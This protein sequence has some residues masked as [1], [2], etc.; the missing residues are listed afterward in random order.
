MWSW[1][2]LWF[3]QAKKEAFALLFATVVLVAAGPL[4]MQFTT[5][6]SP[7]SVASLL[8]VALLSVWAGFRP[9]LLL[10]LGVGA[11]GFVWSGFGW[12]PVVSTFFLISMAYVS[13]T[14]LNALEEQK[15]DF[16]GI[17][18]KRQVRVRKLEEVVERLRFALP[19]QTTYHQSRVRISARSVALLSFAKVVLK[20]GGTETKVSHLFDTLADLVPDGRLL[21]FYLRKGSLVLARVAPKALEGFKG[22][23]FTAR[24][25]P[26]RALLG[27]LAPLR[28]PS[29]IMV[30]DG[31]RVSAGIPLPLGNDEY[32]IL[33]VGFGEEL[34]D[35][36]EDALMDILRTAGAAMRLS[37]GISGDVA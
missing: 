6:A 22:R 26:F 34:D 11:S 1:L 7:V 18:R 29:D 16:E 2:L 35:E 3:Q 36:A 12:R 33:L 30:C 8:S 14:R 37:R 32:A 9:A 4:G 13:T 17:V 19:N 10:S 21:L 15:R 23:K 24:Q 5:L 28:F 25:E 20:P 27:G 31:L